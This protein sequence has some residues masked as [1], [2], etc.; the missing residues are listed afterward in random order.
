MSIELITLLIG[1]TFLVQII[2]GLPL[3]W[4]MGSTS[5]IFT[6]ILFEPTTMIMLVGRM[7]SSIMMNYTLLAIP[8]FVLMAAILQKS[9]ITEQL[10][11][12]VHIWSGNLRGGLAI[13][14]IIS[15]TLMAAMVG[16]VGAEIV[17]FGL[18]AVP[19]MLN[20]NYDK[21]LALGSVCAG[22]GMAT[23]IPPSTTFII[24]GMITGT[25]I[26]ELFI[27]G[28]IPGLILAALFIGYILI[29][30]LIK[31]EW[32]PA[33]PLEERNLP[34]RKKLSLL[35]GLIMPGFLATGVLGSIYAGIATPTEAGAVGC[36]GAVISSA[37]NRKLSWNLL[38]ESVYQTILI[39]CF[40][41]WLFFGA[42]ALIGVYTLAGGD[43]FVRF[44][45][46][47]L[48][49]GKWGAIIGMQ[50]IIIFLGMFLDWIGILFL[51]MPLF[52]PI[53]LDMGFSP[54]WFGVVFCMN[55]HIGYLSPPFGPS[56]FIL[57]S[58]TPKGI[59]TI[60]IYKSVM[61]YLWLTLVALALT[62]AF[63]ELSLWLP[64][65]M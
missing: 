29:V 53:I 56:V 28:I 20:R 1:I 9:D 22:G 25:S 33:A 37:I 63:P 64:S 54:I 17:A 41:A 30:A 55:V 49:Y 26:G 27:A 36:I 52:L 57:K 12:A 38:K 62:M 24:Y 10:F 19:E 48:P 34:L 6:L 32:A 18:L 8:L 51:T 58:V 13:G 31:P 11:R 3:A 15:C 14:T 35:K 21:R 61:P 50:L 45:I 4:V 5:V 47:S 65:K 46:T 40:I 44:A 39:S 42:Q 23:L 2:L 16:V 59:T 43:D 60:D 7:F